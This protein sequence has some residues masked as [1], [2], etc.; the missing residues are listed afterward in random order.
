MSSFLNDLFNSI[1][2]PG[3]TASLITATN[4]AFASLQLLL[5]VLLVATRSIHFLVLSALCAALWW[6]INWF[7]TELEGVKRTD[8]QPEGSNNDG[9]HSDEG[10]QSGDDTE[11]EAQATGDSRDLHKPEGAPFVPGTTD[12]VSR[13]RRRT[14]VGDGGGEVSTEDE[15]E[16]VSEAGAKDR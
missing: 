14:S 16:K 4:A 3:P 7:V 10:G 9:K 15:W 11:T 8:Q 13:L 5:G 2:T 1:F 12:S 6:A